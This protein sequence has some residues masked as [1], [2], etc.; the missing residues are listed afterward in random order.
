MI[1]EMAS[2]EPSVNIVTTTGRIAD[3]N[4]DRLAVVE[5]TCRL[6]SKSCIRRQETAQ[7][8]HSAAYCPLEPVRNHYNFL[9]IINIPQM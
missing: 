8:R 1:A 9:T 5:V 6:L 7:C 2:Q 4:V 3:D